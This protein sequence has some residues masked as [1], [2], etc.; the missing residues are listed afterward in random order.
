MNNGGG[1]NW[2]DWDSQWSEWQEKQSEQP[3]MRDPGPVSG[4]AIANE[5]QD[6]KD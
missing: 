5:P 6:E 4:G 3:D 1:F 2:Q